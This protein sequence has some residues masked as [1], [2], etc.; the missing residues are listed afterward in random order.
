[1][2]SYGS[3]KEHDDNIVN[4]IFII[5]VVL[6]LEHQ[7]DNFILLG[8][9]LISPAIFNYLAHKAA[10]RLTVFSKAIINRKYHLGEEARI[11]DD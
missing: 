4:Y 3:S 8:V 9:V 6:V 11:Q 2:N 7:I 1:M 10:N 5:L